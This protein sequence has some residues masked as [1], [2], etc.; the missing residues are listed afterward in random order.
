MDAPML[1]AGFRFDPSDRQLILYYLTRKVRT[2]CFKVPY[3]KEVDVYNSHPRDLITQAHG[4]DGSSSSTRRNK[5]M[6]QYYYFFTQR[7]RKHEQGK[8]SRAS[9]E[10]KNGASW[11]ANSGEQNVKDYKS[12]KEI[13]LKTTLVYYKDKNPKSKTN[14][15]MHEYRL[16]TQESIQQPYE[17]VICRVY[18]RTWGVKNKEVGKDDEDMHEVPEAPTIDQQ[19]NGVQLQ[20]QEDKCC[21]NN[22]QGDD[23]EDSWSYYVSLLPS[24][25]EEDFSEVVNHH[26]LSSSIQ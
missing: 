19:E 21:I 12:D 16:T 20:E 10:V 2:P 25:I 17:W 22:Q 18:K 3:I 4:G 1:P 8:S 9:R 6:N 14:W 7:K 23:G 15:I 24:H 26:G 11:K 13:G 5:N